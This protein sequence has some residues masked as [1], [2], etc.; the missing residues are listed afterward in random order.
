[1]P[2]CPECRQEFRRGFTRCEE[3]RVDLVESLE[4]AK[5]RMETLDMIQYLEKRETLAIATG[6]LDR[7]TMLKD[8]LCSH[9]IANMI[10]R[11][12]GE[13]CS[14]GCAPSLELVIA[15]ED[16]PRA[17]EHLHRQFKELVRAEGDG[18]TDPDRLDRVFD[19][20]AEENPCPACEA[21]VPK[22]A[23]ECPEC[24][25]YVGAPEGADGEDP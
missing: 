6:Q 25:L 16:L 10:R 20:A 13:C 4:S 5:P 21:R 8:L 19:L 15:A 1:M 7:L 22:G 23:T 24:G 18:E 11:P 2:F 12:G 14:T 9:G 17:V 3:C